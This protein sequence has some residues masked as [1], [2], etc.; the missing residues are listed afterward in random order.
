[1]SES[2]L[3]YE[4]LPCL[5]RYSTRPDVSKEFR[6][7]TFNTWYVSLHFVTSRNVT[8]L[9]FSTSALLKNN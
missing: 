5:A 9:E 6:A 7:F 8:K 4:L 2:I 3:S 1:L